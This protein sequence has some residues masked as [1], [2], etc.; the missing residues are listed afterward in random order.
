[1]IRNSNLGCRRVK[2]NCIKIQFYF[3]SLD[4]MWSGEAPPILLFPFLKPTVCYS[5]R[6][7]EDLPRAIPSFY[8][9]P[10]P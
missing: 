6:I 9:A 1:M 10:I 5:K 2:T 4:N 7:S 8:L 3:A